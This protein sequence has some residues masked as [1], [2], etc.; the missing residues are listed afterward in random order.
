MITVR[1]DN[2]LVVRCLHNEARMRCESDDTRNN[3][4]SWTY[5]GITVIS[6]PCTNKTRVFLGNPAGS[7][8]HECGIIARLDKAFQEP[9]I[10]RIS[11]PYGCT[12]MTNSGITDISAV[13]VLGTL[14]DLYRPSLQDC[15]VLAK[16]T[17]ARIDTKIFICTCVIAVKDVILLGRRNTYLHRAGYFLAL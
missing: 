8:T 15:F 16:N 1:P 4:I 6:V 7:R 5:D 3:T 11:G 12:D 13:I 14:F 9:S 10:Q 17:V 2:S